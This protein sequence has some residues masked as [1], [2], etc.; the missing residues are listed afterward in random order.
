MTL[1]NRP[2][3]GVLY[4]RNSSRDYTPYGTLNVDG[5]KTLTRQAETLC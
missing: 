5:K 4:S 2:T 1:E 3:E